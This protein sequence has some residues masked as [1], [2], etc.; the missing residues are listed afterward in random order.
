MLLT[1]T[2]I[3]SDF[4]YFSR[5]NLTDRRVLKAGIHSPDNLHQ[6]PEGASTYEYNFKGKFT[7]NKN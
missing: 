6:K 7:E 3:I 4:L 2:F 1:S 5:Y